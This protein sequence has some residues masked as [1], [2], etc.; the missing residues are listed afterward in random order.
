MRCANLTRCTRWRPLL[1]GVPLGL[2][3][4]SWNGTSLAPVSSSPPVPL[5]E[6]VRYADLSHAAQSGSYG[7]PPA[8]RGRKV[9]RLQKYLEKITSAHIVLSIQK[10]RQ[11]AE[12]TLRVRD[13]TIRGEESTADVYSSIDLVVEKL[14]R[15]L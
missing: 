13:L 7:S 6:E 10:Y 9:G 12:V 4:L 5:P 15:Q 1:Q 11:I 14:E 2:S 3:S 8:L